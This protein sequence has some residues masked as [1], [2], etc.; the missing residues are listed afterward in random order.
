VDERQLEILRELG[1]Q[2]SVQAVAD[3][4]A[5]TP[6]AVS[7]Q[8]KLLQREAR[9]P[10]TRR[11]GRVL[12]LTPEGERLATAA[13][14][15]QTAMSR[16]REIARGLAT[17]PAGTVSVCAF[18]SAALAFFAPLA[19]CF[20][21]G[22]INVILSDEDV[23]QD[24]FPPLTSRYDI[25]IAHRLQHTRNWPD[26]VVVEPLL[27]E[28]L[29]IALPADHPL[30]NRRSLRAKDVARQP[31]ITTH[32]GFPVGATLESIATAAGRPIEIR[33][34]VNEFTIVAE[35]VRAGQGLAFLPRW[36]Q[37]LPDGVVLRP[38]ADLSVSR[39]LDA[40]IR[41]ENAARPA[42]SHVVAEL[43][44][45]ASTLAGKPAADTPEPLH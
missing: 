35:L 5:I 33:H 1:E 13:V 18:N 40:L 7:Q 34:R 2:G 16:A 42:V 3:A 41:P 38:L 24:G 4:L 25:V 43:K 31:W 14:D 23:A 17:S 10:L 15:V 6:S 27:R 30:A 26:Q 22:G 8:L 12:R 11:V 9:V 39:V 36:T 44:T 19:T 45:I 29:D 20:P 21:A 32:H 37:P 28:R